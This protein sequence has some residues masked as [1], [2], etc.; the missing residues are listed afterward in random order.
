MTGIVPSVGVFARIGALN[1]QRQPMLHRYGNVGSV[2]DSHTSANIYRFPLLPATGIR[3]AVAVRTDEGFIT[4]LG[5][6][7]VEVGTIATPVVLI[8]SKTHRRHDQVKRYHRKK[9]RHKCR[10]LPC[11]SALADTGPQSPEGMFGLQESRFHETATPPIRSL[12]IV[13]RVMQSRLNMHSE[14]RSKPPHRGDGNASILLLRFSILPLFE[15][16]PGLFGVHFFGPLTSLLQAA[17]RMRSEHVLYG[18]SHKHLVW[19]Q[20]DNQLH[21]G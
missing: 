13:S 3:S 20:F 9:E 21:A 12:V 16:P 1:S 18:P 2:I 5:L 7:I 15:S 11:V 6:S 17:G 14:K 4:R 8:I 10:R 19:V